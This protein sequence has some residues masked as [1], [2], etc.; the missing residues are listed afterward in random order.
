MMGFGMV[1]NAQV[2][3]SEPEFVG[4]YYLLTSDFTYVELPKEN[5]SMKKHENKV[6]KWSKLVKGVS[7]IGS[8]AGMVG[9]GTAGSLSGVTTSAK[10][11][12][13]ARGVGSAATSVSALAG[14]N[15]M[16]IVFEGKS[17][18]C[19]VNLSD[20]DLRIIIKAEGND[21]NPV[22]LYRIVRFNTTKKER[23][24]QWFEISSSLLGT[25]DAEKNGYVSFLGTKYGESSY[26]V[27]IPASSLSAG[28]YGI[29]YLQI[30]S[31]LAIPVATF[32]VE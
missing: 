21:T 2:T 20:G 30:E 24:V 3:V 12:S 28:Q 5:G 1:A 18:D 8:V 17:S 22:D 7:G 25:S 23:W 6:S 13:A 11:M 14:A 15:G 29:F 19:S 31:A 26:L 32:A 10:V 16:D 9:I 4:S 27:T